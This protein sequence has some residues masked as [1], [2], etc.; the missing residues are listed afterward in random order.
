MSPINDTDARLTRI[1]TKLDRL[2]DRMTTLQTGSVTWHQV[3]E[4]S[5]FFSTLAA[6]VVELFRYGITK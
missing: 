4:I 3:A 6:A 5:A 1:E 2:F